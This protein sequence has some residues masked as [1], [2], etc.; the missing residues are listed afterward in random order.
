MSL[1]HELLVRVIHLA[2]PPSGPSTKDERKRRRHLR[3]YALVSSAWHGAA[4]DE[5]APHFFVNTFGAGWSQSDDVAFERIMHAKQRAEERTKSVRTLGIFGDKHLPPKSARTLLSIFERA[6]EMSL[7]QMRKPDELLMGS[8]YVRS[9]RLI[10]IQRANFGGC[11]SVLTRLVL[12]HCCAEYLPL[13]LT[14]A[15]F[16]VLDTLIL[17]IKRVRHREQPVQGWEEG[18][19]PPQVRA[20]CFTGQGFAWFSAFFANTRLKHLHMGEESI[21]NGYLSLL[22]FLTQP[23]VSFSADWT[24]ELFN[25][26][27]LPLDAAVCA[28]LPAFKRL[29]DLR[30]YEHK[31]EPHRED[32]FAKFADEVERSLLSEGRD[33]S[34]R[35]IGKKLEV[36]EW[37]P[38]HDPTLVAPAPRLP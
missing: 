36:A 33:L 18:S 21:Q 37:D 14:D 5:A 6:A 2:T 4:L 17:N 35:M 19:R 38:L 23:L 13:T 3:R 10:E 12:D 16:P 29:I 9:L 24:A 28:A 31:A 34:I 25:T 20:L 15:N 32:W 7:M 11:Y 22:A 1:P 8:Q 30:V 26:L 27:H